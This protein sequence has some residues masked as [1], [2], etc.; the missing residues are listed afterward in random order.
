MKQH[1]ENLLN[2]GNNVEILCV[3]CIELEF[4]YEEG[5]GCPTCGYGGEGKAEMNCKKGYWKEDIEYGI[6][7]YREKI[8]T[9]KTCKDYKQV[10]T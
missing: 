10:K 6:N 3:F 5:G 4:D 9:A 1:V 8:L 2:V 7:A